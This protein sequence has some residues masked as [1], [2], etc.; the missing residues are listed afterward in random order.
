M[1]KLTAALI[2]HIFFLLL[3]YTPGVYAV[4][5]SPSMYEASILLKV[6]EEVALENNF[7][8]ARKSYKHLARIEEI[9]LRNI[10]ARSALR[11][12]L[13]T[14]FYQVLTQIADDTINK[15]ISEQ[16]GKHLIAAG[17]A[18][19]MGKLEDAYHVAGNA[20]MN[21]NLHSYPYGHFLVARIFLLKCLQ[22]GSFCTESRKVHSIALKYNP[23]LIYSY[24]DIGSLYMKDNKLKDAIR[25]YKKVSALQSSKNGLLNT[26]GLAAKYSRLKS[27]SKADRKLHKAVS[28]GMIAPENITN[29]IN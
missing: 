11:H 4:K 28:R 21:E 23:N 6:F 9:N 26:M 19:K 5:N 15:K 24:L 2:T 27:W 10:S 16:A 7:K 13:N 12:G 1:G 14:G 8:F 22:D 18:I 3:L 29:L 25:T 20:I 17:I